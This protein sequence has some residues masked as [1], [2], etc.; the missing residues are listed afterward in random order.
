MSIALLNRNQSLC[1][2]SLPPYLYSIGLP[3]RRIGGLDHDIEAFRIGDH[4]D[5][6]REF[7]DLVRDGEGFQDIT[8]QYGGTDTLVRAILKHVIH[9]GRVLIPL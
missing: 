7:L 2:F 1:L 6:L 3:S 4:E 9:V 8:V 5:M